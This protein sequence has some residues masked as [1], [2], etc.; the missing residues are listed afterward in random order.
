[1][2]EIMDYKESIKVIKSKDDMKF[3]KH[4]GEIISI[5]KINT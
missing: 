1:M 3:G 5:E 2:K 4:F